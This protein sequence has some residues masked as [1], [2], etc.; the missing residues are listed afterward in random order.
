MRE[1]KRDQAKVKRSMKDAAGTSSGVSKKQSNT[2]MNPLRAALT[3]EA[4]WGKT[5]NGADT[6]VTTSSACL[7]MFGR[8]GSV[9]ALDNSEKTLIFEKAWKED[10]EIALKLLFYTR[11]IRGG[12]G[13]RDT[14]NTMI[15]KLASMSRDTVEKNL[16]AIMEF[17]RAKDLYSLIGTP[18]EDAMWDFMK[19]QFNL[20]WDNMNAGKS[21]SLL[22]KWIAT[23]DSKSERTREIGKLTAKKL[24][25]TFKTMSEYKKKLRKMRK[26]LDLPEA[27]MCT[28]KW[29]EIEYSKCSGRFL[30]KFRSAIMK[31][32]SDRWNAY[33]ESVNKGSGKMNAGTITPADIIYQVRTNYRDEL[34]AM[35][36]SLPDVCEGNA[37][38]MCDTSGSM[39]GGCYGQ[40]IKPIDV[41]FGLSLYLAQRNVGPFK[42]MMI[43]FSSYPKCIE[44]NAATLIGNYDIASRAEV[45]YSSTNLEGAFEMLLRTAVDNHVKQEDLPQAIIIVSDMQVNCVKGVTNGRM[46]FYDYIKRMYEAEGYRL[47]QVVFWNVNATNPTFHASASDN[48]V[49]LVSGYSTNVYKQVMENIGTTPYDLMMEVVNSKRYEKLAV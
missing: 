34:E 30:L 9:R 8:A 2:T 28:G 20:D 45:N 42:D 41:A 17:G 14:F 22:A 24:G 5:W 48:G 43:N 11:D 16:W 26:Y 46:T 38:V 31:H 33:I 19:D 21:I 39:T 35:W 32:D 7:D 47:P 36:K 12:Y 3:E 37:I 23:P 44:L 4:S 15:R 6:K 1:T 13:E 27:K 10:K 18:A 40:S 29:D 49:S 25:Y